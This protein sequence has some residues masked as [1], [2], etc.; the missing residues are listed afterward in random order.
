MKRTFV[1]VVAAGLA[2]ALFW[3]FRPAARPGATPSSS[4]AARLP[5][6]SH[7]PA[8]AA[9]HPD[10][11]SEDE[12]NP[13]ADGLNAAAG[14]IHADL[15][16]VASL[17]EAFRTNFPRAGNPVGDNTEITAALAGDNALRLSLIPRDHPAISA[18]GELCD[19]WGIPFF[20]HAES[21]TRMEIRSAGSDRRLWTPDDAVL[22]P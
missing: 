14:D 13:L 8:P 5:A 7:S 18:A 15:R 17:L 10:R 9:P 12:R 6:G 4:A 20:F 1:I 22:S 16:I 3:L 2:L 19:R 21:G 11:L